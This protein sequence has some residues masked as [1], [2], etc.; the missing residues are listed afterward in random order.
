[1]HI[2]ATVNLETID[3]VTCFSATLEVAG[4]R[5]NTV[6]VYLVDGMLID[7]GPRHLQDELVRFYEQA[8]F[9]QVVLTHGHEDHSG[10]AAWLKQHLG[11]PIRMHPI[12][13]EEMARPASYPLYRRI[14]WGIREPF[15]ALPL[16]DG[17]ESRTRRWKVIHTPGHAEDHVALL[18]EQTGTLFSGDLFVA[19]KVKVIMRDESVPITM[20]SLRLLLRQDFQSMFCSHAGYFANGPEMLRRKLAYL[21]NLCGEVLKLHEAG[22]TAVEM[23]RMLFP[24]KPPVVQVSGGEWDSLHLITSILAHYGLPAA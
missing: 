18:D 21:E 2:H 8:S 4:R 17:V 23:D 19:P 15:Q 11:V 14:T 6:Y 22:Y 3:D 13:I 7:T 24:R 9:D 16:A 1:M 5:V 20:E 12:G 10:T